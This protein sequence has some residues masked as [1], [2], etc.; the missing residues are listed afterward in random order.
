M[1]AHPPAPAGVQRPVQHH[2]VEAFI[3]SHPSGTL[4]HLLLTRSSRRPSLSLTCAQ[5]KGIGIMHTYLLS[6]AKLAHPAA[7]CLPLSADGSQRGSPA[8]TSAAASAA[9]VVQSVW[10]SVSLE[11]SHQGGTAAVAA[12][13]A[14]GGA[15]G[16]GPGSPWTGGDSGRG[17]GSA[18]TLHH[19]PSSSLSAQLL[20]PPRAGQTGRRLTG[21]GAEV[22]GSRQAG[23]GADT[24]ESLVDAS[25]MQ[26]VHVA[27]AVAAQKDTRAESSMS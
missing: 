17:L 3:K 4:T 14:A 20:R 15:A 13:A 19:L 23:A 9:K 1:T 12:A 10:S 2:A 18:V 16:F 25:E 11:G 6:P 24:G 26:L 21:H 27:A 5:L 8:A 22:E 7:W